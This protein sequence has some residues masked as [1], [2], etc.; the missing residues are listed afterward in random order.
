MAGMVFASSVFGTHISIVITE[1]EAE[2]TVPSID[3]HGNTDFLTSLKVTP[4]IEQARIEGQV[5]G[6]NFAT[7]SMG[8]IAYIL[9]E[10][11]GISDV[12]LLNVYTDETTISGYLSFVINFYS[13]PKIPVIPSDFTQFQ[14]TESQTSPYYIGPDDTGGSCD[15]LTGY[16]DLTFLPSHCNDGFHIM[17]K[18]DISIPES[19]PEPSV[20]ALISF[21][22]FGM[23]LGKRRRLT[24]ATR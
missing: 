10:T 24:R 1:A 22:L 14:I 4:S 19:I 6:G 11:D 17:V 3:M 16:F 20:L 21:G 8:K 18:S 5:K 12:V 7:P 23:R 2:L 15:G 13:D 9:T